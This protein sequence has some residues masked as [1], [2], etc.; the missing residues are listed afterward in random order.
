MTP[1]KWNLAFFGTL[2][3][4]VIALLP[5]IHAQDNFFG[6]GGFDSFGPGG[7][8]AFDAGGFDSFSNGGFDSFASGGFDSFS[9]GGFD[10][11]EGSEQGITKSFFEVFDDNF[12]PFNDL[13]GNPAGPDT[14]APGPNGQFPVPV[15]TTQPTTQPTQVFVGRRDR[16]SI[17]ISRIVIPTAYDNLPGDFV[18]VFMTIENNG[19]VDLDDTKVILVIPELNIRASEGPFDFDKSDRKN[20]RLVAQLPQHVEPGVYYARIFVYN[21]EKQRIVHREVEV[22]TTQ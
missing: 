21:G 1:L 16:P 17:F 12:Q 14:M 5:F 13:P 20:V 8:D 3:A 22:T 2:T 7:F 10:S 9:K 6:A 4:L 19:D 18:P 15:T 11:S